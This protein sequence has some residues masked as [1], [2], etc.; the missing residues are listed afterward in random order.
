MLRRSKRN[1]NKSICYKE[2]MLPTDYK[3]PFIQYK[4]M[5]ASQRANLPPGYEEVLEVHWPQKHD[6]GFYW[7]HIQK[8][9]NHHYSRISTSIDTFPG[10]KGKCIGFLE[11]LMS[12]KDEPFMTEHLWNTIKSEAMEEPLKDIA[13]G[14][15]CY[16]PNKELELEHRYVV[17]KGY[18]EDPILRTE[19][20]T[21]ATFFVRNVNP[22]M[23]NYKWMTKKD[24]KKPT[25]YLPRHLL[26]PLTVKGEQ[27]F[28]SVVQAHYYK[29]KCKGEQKEAKLV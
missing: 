24:I 23:D 14:T 22:E 9:N 5:T 11:F 16:V 1:S 18:T 13:K 8:R 28:W 10:I 19:R 6:D 3:L 17:V 12:H 29:L 21:A 2:E 20:D 25:G 15:I 27:N 26:I 4:P 7:S